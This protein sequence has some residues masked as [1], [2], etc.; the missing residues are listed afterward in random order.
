MVNGLEGLHQVESW[1]DHAHLQPLAVLQLTV[2]A[3]VYSIW[4]AAVG[5]AGWE[6]CLQMLGSWWGPDW[7]CQSLRAARPERQ[8]LV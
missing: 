4:H 5:V 3:A 2:A 7:D 8:C 1:A 6:T